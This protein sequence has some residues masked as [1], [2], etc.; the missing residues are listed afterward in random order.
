MPDLVR[1]PVDGEPGRSAWLL[2]QSVNPNGPAGGSGQAYAVGDFDGRIFTPAPGD[3]DAFGPFSWA[4]HGPDFYAATS[5]AQ[6]P[7]EFSGP[8][9]WIGWLSNWEYAAVT[10]TAPWRGAATLARSLAV[11]RIAG[12]LRLVQHPVLPAH[13]VPLVP[14]PLRANE[15]R[16]DDELAEVARLRLDGLRLDGLR[17]DGL[18]LDGLRLA[19]GDRR[20]ILR[21]A[22]DA[23]R[24]RL[25]IS[26]P[27]GSAA[28]IDVLAGDGERTRITVEVPAAEGLVVEGLVVEGLVAERRDSGAAR[29]VVDRTHAGSVE[30]HPDFAR[31]FVAPLHLDR[32]LSDRPVADGPV[33]AVRT[34]LEIVVDACSVEVFGADGATS[35]TALVFPSPG[36]R[37]IALVADGPAVVHAVTIDAL[38]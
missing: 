26:V 37:G 34:L 28:G 32:R 17:L 1:V 20:Q 4:D 13:S 14:D 11:R 31:A 8:P 23:V 5:F 22:P 29:L 9:V 12:R 2:I 3:G 33:P 18:R 6:P 10:P 21:H 16:P 35:V 30:V 36:S 7:E 19:A 15:L 24:V 25:E 27:A 38:T